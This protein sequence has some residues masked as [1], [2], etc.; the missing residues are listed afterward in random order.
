MSIEK[1]KAAYAA[2]TPGRWEYDADGFVYGDMDQTQATG[3]GYIVSDPH[4]S[5]MADIDERE[6]TGSSSPT[7]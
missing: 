1:L 4:C 2:A 3:G 5:P 6:G 7:T